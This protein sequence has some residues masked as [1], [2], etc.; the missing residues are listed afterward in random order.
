MVTRNSLHDLALLE[1]L[2]RVQA[3]RGAGSVRASA[4]ITLAALEA[5]EILA[6][7]WR[8]DFLTALDKMEIDVNR[9]FLLAKTTSPL[10]HG[11]VDYLINRA[12]KE[13]KHD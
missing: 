5:L 10:P 3:R 2:L 11:L 7:D 6:P 9:D 1:A 4:V 12:N 8:S 13:I